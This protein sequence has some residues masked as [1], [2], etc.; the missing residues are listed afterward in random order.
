MVEISDKEYKELKGRKQAE[1][2]VKQLNL[3]LC[4]IRKVNQLVIKEKDRDKVIKG[5]CVNLVETRGYHN[6]WIVLLDESNRV[7]ATAESGLGKAFLP[8]A[9][10]LERGK[11]P[12]CGRR[13]LKEAGVIVTPDPSSSC[14]DC[15]LAASYY[16]RAGM[17]V[18]LEY[19]GKVYGLLAV[20]TSANFV[21]DDEE[22]SL[23]REVAGDIAFALRNIKLNEGRKQAE[24]AVKESR[25]FLSNVFFSIQD[26]ISVL[27]KEFNIVMVNAKMEKWYAHAMPLVGK[28]CYQAYQGRSKRCEICPSYESMRTGKLAREVVPMQGPKGR[29]VGWIE[30]FGFPLIDE[31]TGELTGVIE[32]VRDITERRKVEDELRQVEERY[33]TVFENTGNATLILEK[34]RTISLVNR[35]FEVLSGFSREEIE[36]KKRWEEF[37][38]EEDLEKMKEQHELRRKKPGSAMNVY[39]FRFVDRN[40]VVKDILLTVDMIPGTMKSVASLMDITGRKRAEE[41][42]KKS[43]EKF[44]MISE[45]TNDVIGLT[46]FSLDPVYTYLSPSV[47]DVFGYQP[48]ELIGKSALDYI[49]PDDKK[50]LLPLLKKYISMKVKGVFGAGNKNIAEMIEFRSKDKSGNWHWAESRVNL[51]GKDSLAYVAR[52]IT[53]R[54]RAEE[55]LQERINELNCLYNISVLFD[56]RRLSVDEMLYQSLGLIRFA[57]RRPEAVCVRIKLDGREFKTDNFRETEWKFSV[58]IKVHGSDLG[59]LTVCYLGKRSRS[60]EPFL[61]GEKKLIRVIAEYLGHVVQHRLTEEDTSNRKEELEKFYK[62]AMGREDRVLELKK[63]VEEL[64][65]RII[66]LKRELKGKLGKI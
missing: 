41:A 55:K 65:D 23:F 26:G 43:E 45:N 1:E 3:V 66:E 19:E 4:S 32:Y 27:D 30:L 7:A 31:K 20:S 21:A 51:I 34:D 10:Q 46:T 8:M 52:D 63:K 17:S 40:G 12:A 9:E 49:H 36:G 29:V 5:V 57:W 11:L 39:E 44:R 58:A 28:K 15:P 61:E 13:A 38:A 25:Q 47:K 56:R 24:D 59:S 35:G 42:L 6:A 2:R 62:I 14:T 37:V 48:E 33:R 64:E 18:R 54:K 50:K 22:R 16:G 53:E 60:D